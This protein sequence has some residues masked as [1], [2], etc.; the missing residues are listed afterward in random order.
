[1]KLKATISEQL[2]MASGILF[3]IGAVVSQLG[4]TWGFSMLG[5]Q[6][7]QTMT[8][9]AGAITVY[10]LGRTSKTVSERNENGEENQTNNKN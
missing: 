10:F 1:M 4:D 3:A 5:M 7:A 8:I 6:I 2:S 9:I